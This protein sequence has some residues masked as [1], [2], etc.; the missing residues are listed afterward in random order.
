MTDPTIIRKPKP[1]PCH[2][3]VEA[4]CFQLLGFAL[5]AGHWSS[6]TVEDER[7]PDLVSKTYVVKVK[8]K[9]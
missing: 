1:E 7:K 2:E 8:V 5:D 3:A 4:A 9:V 6:F